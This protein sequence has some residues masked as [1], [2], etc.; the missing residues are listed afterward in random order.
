MTLPFNPNSLG[1]WQEV[2]EAA[3]KHAEEVTKYLEGPT[4]N[5]ARITAE[6]AFREGAQWLRER[7]R[8]APAHSTQVN[9]GVTSYCTHENPP[10]NRCLGLPTT[11]AELVGK[12]SYSSDDTNSPSALTAQQ[13]PQP[14]YW[15]HGLMNDE[16][17]AAQAAKRRE[18]CK[19]GIHWKAECRECLE[20]VGAAQAHEDKQDG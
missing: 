20:E 4:R 6:H 14:Q 18:Q 13:D 3:I 17:A 5:I 9:E 8:D 19:H 1:A 15:D 7:L 10:C 11:G 2:S 16:E 12:P